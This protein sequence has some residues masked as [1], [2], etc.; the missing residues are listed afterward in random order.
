MLYRG[1]TNL[2]TENPDDIDQA[3]ED[4]K[5]SSTSATRRSI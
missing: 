5:A 3:L 2:N 4:L 1:K